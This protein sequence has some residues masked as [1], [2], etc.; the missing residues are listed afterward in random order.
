MRTEK[1]MG[2]GR[3]LA[4]LTAVLV[5][6]AAQLGAEAI[7]KLA[8]AAGVPAWAGN[9][10][11]SAAYIGLGLGGLLLFGKLV[12]GISGEEWGLKLRSFSFAYPAAALLMPAAVCAVLLLLP[13]KWEFSGVHGEALAE[14]V[15]A[16][17]CY[18]GIATGIVEEA[19]FRGI[20]MT[21]A[22]RRWN[23]RAAVIAPSVL[24][25]CVH[26]LGQP[27]SFAGGV[28][29]A[30]AGTLVG[31][32]FSLAAC[33]SGSIWCGA[34]MHGTWNIFMCGTLLFIGQENDPQV[35][36]SYVLS[37]RNIALT[38]GAFGAEASL[39]AI[40]AYGAAALFFLFRM[41]VFRGTFSGKAHRIE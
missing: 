14:T 18:Y 28:Q 35:F 27:L 17:I 6:A 5:Y 36:A 10:I 13:G 19:L 21:A 23:R 40:A 3:F 8:V 7:G 25:G 1:R 33:E 41:R 26:V 32:A 39:W 38:G 29:V 37:S 24:F 12:L 9:V 15:T 30:L 16:G 22:A 31:I 20:W 4:S 11:V 2:T 34:L